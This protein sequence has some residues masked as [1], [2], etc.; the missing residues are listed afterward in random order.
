MK[1]NDVRRGIASRHVRSGSAPDIGRVSRLRGSK[2]PQAGDLDRV[3]RRSSRKSVASQRTLHFWSIALGIA[4]FAILVAVVA[5]WLRSFFNEE[6]GPISVAAEDQEGSVK[7]ASKFPSPAR[8]EAIDIVKEALTNRDLAKIDILFRHGS[9]TSSD[10][11]DYCSKATERDGTF[12]SYDWMSSLDIDGLLIEGVLV[13]YKGKER[14]NQR[15][16]LLTPDDRGRWQVDFDAFVRTVTPSWSELLAGVGELAQVRVIVIPGVYYNGI[17]RDESVW[18]CYSLTSPDMDVTLCGYCR[19]GSPDDFSLK[20]LFTDG[21]ANARVTL[22]LRRV[23]DAEPRQFEIA[24]ILSR[25]W[26]VP[27]KSTKSNK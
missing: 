8:E 23:K 16:A 13:N 17:F 18:S 21:A 24:R 15:L 26:V 20:K 3:R 27:E 1:P 10:I 14:T 4:A 6:T 25:E 12:D 5:L 11:L 2:A 22:E 19:V 7:I 9:S